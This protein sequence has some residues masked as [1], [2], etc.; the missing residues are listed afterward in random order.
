M[1][2]LSKYLF[3]YTIL[4]VFNSLIKQ[5]YWSH[6]GILMSNNK[7][8]CGNRDQGYHSGSIYELCAV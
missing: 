2:L 4:H 6:G 5:L 7:V 1:N 3:L 8:L